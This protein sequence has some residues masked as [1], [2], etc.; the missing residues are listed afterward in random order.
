[1]ELDQYIGQRAKIGVIIPSTNTAVEYDIQKVIPPG[2]TWHPARFWVESPSL[3]NDQAFLEFL[4]C[5]RET[6]PNAV[7]DILTCFPNHIMMGMSAETFWGGLAGNAEFI[8]RISELMGEEIGLTTGANAVTAALDCFRV[9]NIAVLTPYQPIGDI[10]VEKFF[11][12]TAFNVKK[13]VGLKCDSA[14]SIAATP[15]K[16]VLDSVLRDLDGDD[17]EAIVQ[18]GTNLSTVDIF[19]TLENLL[20]KPCLPINICTVWHALRHNDIHDRFENMGRLLLEF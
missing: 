7:R 17:I 8:E 1:M 6:I 18:V 9:K 15:R 16:V 11:S 10:Q 2:V 5:I 3:T 13:V 19:P 20:A 12:D 14:T 4:D